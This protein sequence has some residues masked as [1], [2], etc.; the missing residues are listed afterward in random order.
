MTWWEWVAAGVTVGFVVGVFI[1]VHWL[2]KI[3]PVPTRWRR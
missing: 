1:V 2:A 3:F